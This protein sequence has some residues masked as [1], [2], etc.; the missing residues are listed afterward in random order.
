[1]DLNLFITTAQGTDPR[2]SRVVSLTDNAQ[3]P[4]P[5]IV[6]NSRL[7]VTIYLV[8]GSGGYHAA[9]G[10]GGQAPRLAIGVRGQSALAYTTTFV[11]VANGWTCTLDLTTTELIQALSALRSGLLVLEFSTTATGPTPT[12]WAT[13]P[14]E[15]LGH[16]SDPESGTAIAS[17]EYYTAAEV[18]ALFASKTD[19]YFYPSI[20][21]IGSATVDQVFD[22]FK[23]RKATRILG[24]QISA[25]VGPTGADLTLCLV[26]SVGVEI[27][28]STVTLAAGSTYAETIFGAPVD[29]IEGAF[30]RAKIK[31]KGSTQPGG[32]LHLK[33]IC[34]PNF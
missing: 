10:A 32:Y 5:A 15:I 34:R 11:Q 22:Y 4:L 2:N 1:M 9:S 12:Y 24:A 19:A 21:F 28:G 17:P 20:V 6:F 30:I 33:L 18:D 31:Q 29:L 26:D 25:Q 8:N 27:A 7:N 13:L 23:A 14:I 3:F 16:V